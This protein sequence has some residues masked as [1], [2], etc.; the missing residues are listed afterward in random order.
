[1]ALGRPVAAAIPR[2]RTAAAA[3]APGARLRRTGDAGLGQRLGADRPQRAARRRRRRRDSTAKRPSPGAKGQQEDRGD[4]DRHLE[5]LAHA[6]EAVAEVD[7]GG[8]VG[9]HGSESLASVA[10]FEGGTAE[11]GG[12][13]QSG[14][15]ER[16]DRRWVLVGGAWGSQAG[17]GG[18]TGAG[19]RD[20]GGRRWRAGGRWTASPASL[21]R[22]VAGRRAWPSP[23]R[24]SSA[25]RSSWCPWSARRSAVHRRRRPRWIAPCRSRCARRRCAGGSWSPSRTTISRTPPLACRCCRA[26]AAVERRALAALARRPRDRRHGQRVAGQRGGGVGRHPEV[27]EAAAL[28]VLDGPIGL[29]QRGEV[30]QRLPP[31]RRQVV[32]SIAEAHIACSVQAVDAELESGSIGA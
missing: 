7:G 5:R 1:M 27:V 32:G 4:E 30:V 6:G 9:G 15:H 18:G 11:G 14:E 19:A 20:A 13:Q 28:H 29:L 24:G 16:G 21:S 22:R 26:A 10:G 31:V 17:R 3:M 2:S 8:Q 23:A 12:E 25:R